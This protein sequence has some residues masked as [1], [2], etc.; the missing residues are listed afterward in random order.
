MKSALALQLM[1]VR[2]L[3]KAKQALVFRW[4]RHNSSETQAVRLPQDGQVSTLMKTVALGRRIL[5]V[6]MTVCCY[7]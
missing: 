1:A 3:A 4:K 5:L 7:V 2:L 6:M